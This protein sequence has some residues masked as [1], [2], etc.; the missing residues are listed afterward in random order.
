MALDYYYQIRD[1]DRNADAFARLTRV[2]RAARTLFLNKTCFNGLYRVNSKG[3]FNVPCGRYKNPLILDEANLRSV[4]HTLQ[5]TTLT[6]LDFQAALE[7]ADSGDFIYLDPPYH[8]LNATASFTGYTAPGFSF[9]DQ[10]RLADTFRD[11]DIKG[12]QVMLSNSCVEPILELYR[13]F[14]IEQ[15]MARRAINSQGQK[16][17]PVSEIVVTNY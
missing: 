13:G 2:Q 15:I 1:L 16:R 6:C 10:K 17:G 3:Q 9:K 5:E 7:T 11:L 4:S 8:P 12:C 14:R